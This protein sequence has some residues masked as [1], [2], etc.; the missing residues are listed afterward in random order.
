M[1]SED[2]C[3]TYAELH[4][5][6]NAFARAVLKVVAGA[7]QPLVCISGEKRMDTYA[8]LLACVKCGV[9]YAVLD[10]ASPPER[11]E[12]IIARCKASLVVAYRTD[13]N[14]IA[15]AAQAVQCTYMDIE[16]LQ[17]HIAE[18]SDRALESIHKIVGTCPAYV[19]FTS[20][21]TGFPKGAVM[22]HDNV[23]NFIS[24]SIS[25]YV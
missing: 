10:S 1:F 22:T 16:Q 25:E 7:P 6:S 4:K 17:K 3:C 21:S 20:G 11:L 14:N 12:K 19:M 15:D 24:W 9:P 5:R 18:E 2:E 8:L 13:T 23:L